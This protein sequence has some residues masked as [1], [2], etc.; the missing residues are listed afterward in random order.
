M[1]LSILMLA[2]CLLAWSCKTSNDSAADGGE[3][4]T[5]ATTAWYETATDEQLLDSVQAQTFRY[6]WEY[7]EP[8]SGLARERFHP[9]GNYPQNDA[10]IVT[11]GGGGFGVMAIL[12]GIKREFI[13]RKEG[14]DRL[15]RIVDF[16]ETADRFHGVWPH[17]LNGETGKVK[18][19]S[20]KDNGG[21]L[22]ESSFLM[23]GLLCVR[24]FCDRT[25]P[26][27]EALAQKIDVLWKDMEW[28]W[29][30]NNTNNLYWHWSPE[31]DFEMNFALEGYNETLITH[32]MAASSPT[33][34]TDPAVY[35]ECWARNG[36]IKA[37]DTYLGYKRVLDHYPTGDSPV[38]PLFWAHYSHL[39]LDPR[40]LEDQYGNYWELNQ[41]HALI[42]YKHCVD[43][44]N[45]FKGYGPDCWG[46]T[47]SY[48]PKNGEIGYASHRPDMD[49]GVI[50][51]T[52]ALSSMPY[53]P[54]ETLAAIRGF[55]KHYGDIL[56]GPAGF[57]DAFRP[58]D[59]WVAPRYLAIDQ[60]P[61]IGMIENYR[62]GM[63]WDLFMSCPE[64]QSGLD[65]L[66]FTVKDS[67]SN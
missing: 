7:A 24:Q 25:N 23:Q 8:K 36:Q 42:H 41:N 49:N 10:H 29:Y 55:Y 9:D 46:L 33:H 1:R 4:P 66:G 39:G 40:N 52:A 3:P 60:G 19:F 59:G 38:G 67:A 31:Y 20:K 22:V 45:D 57:Y 50:S 61:I 30:T 58:D 21:D 14:M 26:A 62:S 17:W 63:L 47:S 11:T 18:P 28:D 51:P 35:H 32:V 48:S 37:E 16:L 53:T 43:N 34:P 5:T 44:P 6:F 27:E 56:L 64:I 12:V 13:T 15:T 65:R 54:K 2:C